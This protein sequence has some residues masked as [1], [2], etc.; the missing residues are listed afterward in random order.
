MSR[1]IASRRVVSAVVLVAIYVRISKDEYGRELGVDRQEE[2]VRD[3]LDREFGPGRYEVVRVYSDNNISAW[4]GAKRPEY[5]DLLVDAAARRFDLVAVWATD[6]LYRRT[7]DLTDII[8]ALGENPDDGVELLA[9]Q[10][11]YYDLTTADGRYYARMDA[12]RA[13]HESDR[14]SERIRLQRA[15]ARSLGHAPERAGFGYRRIFLGR[16]A[17]A[18]LEVIEHE[19]ETLRLA[20]EAILDP[21]TPATQK[22]AAGF[23]NGAG[24]FRRSGKPWDPSDLR[25]SLLSPTVAGLIADPYADPDD[26]EAYFVGLWEPIF[27][28]ATWELLRAELAKPE[29]K[30]SRKRG[31]YPLRG[32]LV[33]PAG[34]WLRGCRLP[35]AGQT[36]PGAYGRRGYRSPKDAAQ[37]VTIDAGRTETLLQDL[38]GLYVGLLPWDADAV[39]TP[40][41]DGNEVSEIEALIAELAEERGKRTITKAEWEKART[42]LLAD[43]ERARAKE[44]E[45]RR[46]LPASKRHDDIAKR[47]ELAEDDGGISEVERW[48][49]VRWALG[50]VTVLP[51]HGG[52]WAA[53]EKAI[54]KRL[55]VGAGPLAEVLP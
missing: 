27:D 14:K 13:Q 25:K 29:R 11:S 9:V 51:S 21:V 3:R 16:H 40:A 6:R 38:V 2:A 4:S 26:D 22:D 15:Q 36:G 1:R 31:T 52:R 49:V 33:D 39:P 17:G 24:R 20:A 34:L 43:L 12:A 45:R 30:H 23:L 55:V 48:R 54:R 41:E 7:E 37:K 19:A 44:P 10:G 42:P 18:T 8:R 5:E 46:S 35:T 32:T 28:R 50:E 47:W 53:S